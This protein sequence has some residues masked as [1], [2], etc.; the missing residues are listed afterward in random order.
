MCSCFDLLYSVN[1]I[2]LAL[3]FFLVSLLELSSLELESLSSL[4]IFFSFCLFFLAFFLFSLRISLSKPS[5]IWSFYFSINLYKL[6]SLLFNSLSERDLKWW[7]NLN[8]GSVLIFSLM[9]VIFFIPNLY[10][11]WAK[12]RSASIE[13]NFDLNFV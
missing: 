9:N 13:N 11:H 7:S 10:A 12:N 3:E 4:S 8:I 1:R 2:C 6:C 5:S